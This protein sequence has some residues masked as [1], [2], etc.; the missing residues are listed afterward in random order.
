MNTD[1]ELDDACERAVAELERE[2]QLGREKQYRSWCDDFASFPENS[3]RKLKEGFIVDVELQ[4][5]RWIQHGLDLIGSRK[6]TGKI[7]GREGADFR[8]YL[9]YPVFQMG[10]EVFLKG[11]WL[12]QY[13]ECRN[14]KQNSYVVPERRTY[15]LGQ[16][17]NLSKEHDLLKIIRAVEMIPVYQNDAWLLRFLRILSGC[18]WAYYCPAANSKRGWANERY[19]K[20]FYNDELKAGGADALKSYPEHWLVSRL[21]QEAAE[22]IDFLWRKHAE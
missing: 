8:A 18:S 12:Y 21:F 20:R 13:E 10:T 4:P 9:P 14:L 19:P 22:R 17:I 5:Y 11:M 1:T 7:G 2:A 16:L 15:Y 6:G 3:K